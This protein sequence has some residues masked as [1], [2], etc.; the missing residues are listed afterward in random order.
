MKKLPTKLSESLAEGAT[1]NLKDNKLTDVS[2]LD[3]TKKA[4]YYFDGNQITKATTAQTIAVSN[5]PKLPPD[6][7]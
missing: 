2:D 1:V 6:P 5:A 3:L 4:T 7:T